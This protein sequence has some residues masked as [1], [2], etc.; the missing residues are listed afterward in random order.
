MKKAKKLSTSEIK[1]LAKELDKTLRTKLKG[2]TKKAPYVARYVGAQGHEDRKPNEQSQLKFLGYQLPDQRKMAATN[3]KLAGTSLHDL[4]QDDQWSVWMQVWKDSDVYEIRQIVL[5]WMSPKKMKDLRHKK[6][7]DLFDLAADIDNWALSDGLSSF[8]AEI[9]ENDHKHLP[10][11]L[12]WNKSKN[13]WLRRQ[14]IVGLYCYAR[15]RKTH[16]PAETALKLIESLLDDPHF[17]VQRGV[18]WT[19]REVDRVDSELQRQFVRKHL[20]RI[21]GVAWFATSELYPLSMRKEL[22]ELRKVARKRS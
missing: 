8:L 1:K 2:P 13:P 9:L 22:V 11:Y 4:S 5:L 7:K 14:S 3:W 16:V 20:H 10:T 6:A 12:K 19:L 18:G 21:G 17:Y 15:M